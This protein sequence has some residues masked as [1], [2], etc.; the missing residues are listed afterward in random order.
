MIYEESS[1]TSVN[2][3]TRQRADGVKSFK[4]CNIK[5]IFHI[6]SALGDGKRKES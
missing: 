5:E 4:I 1:S 6:E 2:F 3:F